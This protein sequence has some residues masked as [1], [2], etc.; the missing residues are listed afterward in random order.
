[1]NAQIDWLI[2]CREQHVRRAAAA[3][4]LCAEAW[5]RHGDTLELAHL[6]AEWRG[7]QALAVYGD[8]RVHAAIGAQRARAEQRQQ[9]DR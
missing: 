5:E 9:H 1:M 2:G 8:R 6:I 7:E 4:R 3:E